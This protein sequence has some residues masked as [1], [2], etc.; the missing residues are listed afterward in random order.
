M[1]KPSFAYNILS[2]YHVLQR[3]NSSIKN[4]KSGAQISIFCLLRTEPAV[5]TA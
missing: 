2:K 3:R 5:V 4:L 1:S